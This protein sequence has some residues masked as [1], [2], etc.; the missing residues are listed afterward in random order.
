LQRNELLK[1]PSHL[2]LEDAP[3]QQPSGIAF[4][5]LVSAVALAVTGCNSERFVLPSSSTELAGTWIGSAKGMT[6][7]MTFGTVPCSTSYGTCII[8]SPAS[9]RLDSTG[10]SGSFAVY[11]LWFSGAADNSVIMN[12]LSDTTVVA[13]NYREQ[14]TGSVVGGT[15]LVGAIGLITPTNPR[16]AL[17]TLAASSI[18]FTRQ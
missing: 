16:S 15:R 11:V 4:R 9:Y 8:R 7:T 13:V 14:F 2:D 17:D 12:F 18:S 6:L 1:L 10:E 3:M 5:L